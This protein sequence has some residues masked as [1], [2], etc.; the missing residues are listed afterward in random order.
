LRAQSIETQ[1][2]N[3]QDPD[4][5]ALSLRVL[6]ENYPDLALVVKAWPGL[7]DPIKA[8]VLALIGSV[9]K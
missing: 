4:S 9:G 2:V 7:P 1:A 3:H 5:L 8:A 6:P